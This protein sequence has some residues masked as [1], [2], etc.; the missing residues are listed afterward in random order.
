MTY[1]PQ[2]SRLVFGFTLVELMAVVVIAALLT[3]VAVPSYRQY[4][5]RSHRTEAKAALLRAAANQERYYLVHKEYT[6]D[7]RALGF[8]TADDAPTEN[9]RY[10]LSADIEDGQTFEI[11]ATVAAGMLDDTDCETFSIDSEGLRG[12]SPDPDERCW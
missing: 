2:R 8:G 5:Q 10:T 12:A 4:V 7:M 3:M 1:G 9:G 6:D 11:V